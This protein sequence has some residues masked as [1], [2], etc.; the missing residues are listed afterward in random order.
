MGTLVSLDYGHFNQGS[1]LLGMHPGSVW[2]QSGHN[3]A[4]HR[5]FLEMEKVSHAQTGIDTA[6]GGR[7]I[8]T[9][10]ERRGREVRNQGRRAHLRDRARRRAD[11]H[12]EKGSV[13]RICTRG[14]GTG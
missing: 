13:V 5:K 11:H 8:R 2:S 12:L 3:P 1:S 10:V 14:W 6:C 4:Y 7:W 9:G